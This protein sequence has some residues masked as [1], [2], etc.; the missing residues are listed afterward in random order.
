[1]FFLTTSL[2][3]K[4]PNTELF[5]GCIFLHSDLIWRDTK[6]L[7]V[8]SPNARKYG[9][10]MTPYLDT[11]RAVRILG[12][13][14]VHCPFTKF[15]ASKLFWRLTFKLRACTQE[16]FPMTCGH[17]MTSSLDP[18]FR[19]RSLTDTMSKKLKT[20]CINE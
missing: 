2:R 17:F 16:S 4:C 10:E 5:L 12:L 3:E 20:L 1:M 14:I 8:F 7:S 13:L 6:Y 11:F 15:I 19:K 9:S 18:I